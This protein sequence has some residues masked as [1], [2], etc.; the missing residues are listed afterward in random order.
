MLSQFKRAVLFA[1][2]LL[3]FTIGT[4][5]KNADQNTIKDLLE[6]NYSNSSTLSH[7]AGKKEEK[8]TGVHFSA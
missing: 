6:L 1:A 5:I 3:A 2:L 7:K 8:T 4:T